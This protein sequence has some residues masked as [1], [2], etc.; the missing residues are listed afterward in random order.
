MTDDGP[1]DYRPI[2]ALPYWD[3]IGT[4]ITDAVTETAT[5][6]GRP[7]RSLYPAAVAFV[8]WCWQSRGTPLE[9]HR[10]FRRATVEEFIH[11][12]MTRFTN[13]SRATRSPGRHRRN[14]IR[15]KK[16]RRCTVGRP[17]KERSEG[18]KMRSRS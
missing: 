4:F 13:G 1:Y 10:I 5:A 3:V 18:G 15:P 6:S 8:L 16:S 7:E 9:R 12:A 2:N 11:L 17:R 14:P